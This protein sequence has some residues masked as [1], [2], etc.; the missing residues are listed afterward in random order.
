M[1]GK[2]LV[3]T[4]DGKQKPM[5]EAIAEWRELTAPMESI[6]L[7][8]HAFDPSVQF[9]CPDSGKVMDMTISTIRRINAAISRNNDQTTKLIST[10]CSAV[11]LPM[12]DAP[13]DGTKIILAAPTGQVWPSC[14]WVKMRKVANRWE[15]VGLGA[16]PFVPAAWIPMPIF[17]PNKKS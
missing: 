6:G 11:W 16:I 15:S 12:E 17:E 13:K 4:P 1:N 5:E 9:R 3:N 10:H 7:I 14:R 8:V 2:Q